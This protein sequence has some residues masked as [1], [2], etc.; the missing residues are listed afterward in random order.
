VTGFFLKNN[1]WWRTPENTLTSENFEKRAGI[2]FQCQLL[3][4]ICSRLQVNVGYQH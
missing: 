2:G 1:N 3:F 4:Y